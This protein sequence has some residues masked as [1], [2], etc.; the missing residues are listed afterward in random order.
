MLFLKRCSDVF[1]ARRS[2]GSGHSWTLSLHV[3]PPLFLWSALLHVLGSLAEPPPRAE[4]VEGMLWR[5]AGREA[6]APSLLADFRW[7]SAALLVLTAVQARA[8]A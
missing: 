6:P 4:Q 2:A 5:P 3:S 7:Q 8:L 1:E